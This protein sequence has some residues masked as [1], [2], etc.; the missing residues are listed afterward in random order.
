MW[1]IIL[2]EFCQSFA[3][4]IWKFT[5]L[6]HFQKLKFTSNSNCS[7]VVWPKSHF[8]GHWKVLYAEICGC[9]GKNPKTSNA[10][11]SSPHSSKQ[12]VNRTTFTASFNS[13][14]IWLRV[15]FFS[16]FSYSFHTKWCLLTALSFVWLVLAVVCHVAAEVRRYAVGFIECVLP[17][18]DQTAFAFRRSCKI[19]SGKGKV[20]WS[21]D[22]N[23]EEDADNL[24]LPF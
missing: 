21:G 15:L 3:G 2:I 6:S 13:I 18:A 9:W 23:L 5:S 8:Q 4:P 22:H 10:K 12:E 19:R 11:T 20:R 7:H 16:H 1:I 24:P 17:A 14:G